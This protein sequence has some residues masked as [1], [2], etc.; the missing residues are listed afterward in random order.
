MI[1]RDVVKRYKPGRGKLRIY[2]VTDGEDMQSP[3]PYMGM[4]GMNPLM[5]GLLARGYEVKRGF[6][7]L[8]QDVDEGSIMSTHGST[9]FIK[10]MCTGSGGTQIQ[11]MR[12]NS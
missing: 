12:S 1:E 3:Y 2:V 11:P 9:L 4:N 7:V 6:K 10:K 8:P 5:E